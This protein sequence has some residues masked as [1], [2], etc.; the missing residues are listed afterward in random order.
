MPAIAV[1]T[2]MIAAHAARRLVSVSVLRRRDE[3]QIRITG[4]GEQLAKRIH[5]FVDAHC[6]IIDGAEVWLGVCRQQ[7]QIE[8][9]DVYEWPDGPLYGKKFALQVVDAARCR[10]DEFLTK[11]DGGLLFPPERG[12]H[13]L[14]RP[15]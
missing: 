2:A 4:G 5:H 8:P 13:G 11:D 14:C 1:G 7:I 10:L 6:M 15:P 12:E 9:H 3:R